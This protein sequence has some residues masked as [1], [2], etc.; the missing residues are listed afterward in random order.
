MASST[1]DPIRRTASLISCSCRSSE[2]RAA[3]TPLAMAP[4]PAAASSRR[5][6][7]PSTA[8]WSWLS[9]RSVIPPPVLAEPTGD[10][11]LGQLV[12]R[13]REDVDGRRRLD[14]EARAIL[15]HRHE[16]RGV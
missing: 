5:S 15:T 16:H 1:S 11:V 6:T 10:V 14:D 4:F 7:W 2:S 12:L 3:G 8:V 13:V 9:A